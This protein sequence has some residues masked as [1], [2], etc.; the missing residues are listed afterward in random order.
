MSTRRCSMTFAITSSRRGPV[1]LLTRFQLGADA[2]AP[3]L[4]GHMNLSKLFIVRA[5]SKARAND[6]TAWDELHALWLLDRTLWDR[7]ELISKLI[8][9]A[10]SRMVNAAAAKMPLPV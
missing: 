2:P 10:T 6:P 1:I 7:P 3:N 4:L 9:L 5:L 8:A